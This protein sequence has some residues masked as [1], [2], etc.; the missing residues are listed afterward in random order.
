MVIE[1]KVYDLTKFIDEQPGGFI[2][3]VR[4]N[5]KRK[6][7]KGKEKDKGKKKKGEQREERGKESKREKKEM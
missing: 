4:E 3:L 7:K 5:G 6:R 1:G 2:I